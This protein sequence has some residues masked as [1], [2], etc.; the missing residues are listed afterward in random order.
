VVDRQGWAHDRKTDALARELAGSYRVVKRYQAEVAAEDF[1]RA[2]CVLLYYWLQVDRL[3]TLQQALAR[4]KERL[5]IGIC[6]EL[7]LDGA[8]REPGVA[9]LASL[10]RAI[11]VISERL[12]QRFAPLL[13]RPIFYTPNG[14]DTQLFRPASTAPRLAGPLRVGW[15][16]SLTNH[17]PEQRGVQ[18]FIAPAVEAVPGVELRLAAREQRWRSVE[19]MVAFYHSLDVYVCASRSEG[20]PNPCLEAAACGLPVVTTPVGSM[21]EL[22][23]H[24]ENGLFVE[25]DTADI[26]AALARLRDDPELRAR[27]GRAARQSVEAWDWRFQAPNYAEMFR[28]VLAPR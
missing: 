21:P 17:G 20:A 10:P 23:R 24:G 5:V 27:L 13:G 22:I 19:E 4:A 15:A 18:E 12:R 25:R 8:W 1:D 16:G 28:A 9:T 3:G 26:A 7:E 6:S 11:F 14:V 2:D